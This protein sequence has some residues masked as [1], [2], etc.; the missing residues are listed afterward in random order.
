MSMPRWV[1][2][3]HEAEKKVVELQTR[4]A[5]LKQ[6]GTW[7]VENESSRPDMTSY[8]AGFLDAMRLLGVR[9]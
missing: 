4:H 6:G 5:Y 8:V 7:H 9:P 3:Q 2:K 1:E